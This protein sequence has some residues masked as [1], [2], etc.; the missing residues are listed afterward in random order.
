M[1]RL[2]RGKYRIPEGPEAETCQ[3]ALICSQWVSMARVRRVF[4]GG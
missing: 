2:D 4:S 1:D 3:L